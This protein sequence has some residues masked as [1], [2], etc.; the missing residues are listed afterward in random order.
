MTGPVTSAP[1]TCLPSH[2]SE[3]SDEPAAIGLAVT[4]LVAFG[5][6]RLRERRLKVALVVYRIT[7]A[8]AE[9]HR[10][11]AD[12]LLDQVWPGEVLGDRNRLQVH[13][14]RLRKVLGSERILS[15]AGS[16]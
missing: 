1:V 15:H 16:Y 8:V 12:Q 9:G 13:I 5:A 14:S 3:A 11:P 2:R 6:W 7:P 10:V 4:G